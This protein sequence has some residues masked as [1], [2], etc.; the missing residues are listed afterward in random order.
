[1]NRRHYLALSTAVSGTLAGCTVLRST[2][3]LAATEEIDERNALLRFQAANED[4]LTVNLK[5]L[6]LDRETREYYPFRVSTWQR[7]G[8]ELSSLQL[9][10]RSPPHSSGFSPA[11]IALREGSH[12]DRATLSQEGDDPSTT[13]VDMPDLAG[14]GHA[15][16]DIGFLLTADHEQDPQRLWM[17][18]EA[19]LSADSLRRS[20]YRADGDLTVAFP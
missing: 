1:M 5:K 15:T 4:V 9:R 12:A 19:S 18:C 14:I 17:R 7:D 2:P 8:V 13:V 10:F 3:A 20:G 6:F 11:G 16:V